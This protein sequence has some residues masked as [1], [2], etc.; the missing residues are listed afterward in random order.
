[1]RIVWS[2]VLVVV[3]ALLPGLDGAHAQ[4]RPAAGA[5]QEIE[6]LFAVLGASGCRFQRNGSW[7]DAE[8]AVGH[9]RRKHDYLAKRGLVT[10]AESL[11][12]LAASKSSLTGRPYLVQCPGAEPVPSRTWFTRRLAE[13][14]A[15]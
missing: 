11:I 2:A 1:M 10:D 9:L 7:H 3:L 15:R 12:E 13:I 14:R 5:Q 4:P 8:Q 6:R